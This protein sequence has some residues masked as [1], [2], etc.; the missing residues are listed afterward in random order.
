MAVFG[1]RCEA[2]NMLST[3]PLWLGPLTPDAKAKLPGPPAK[4]LPPA[5][6]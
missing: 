6:P 1:E 4:T 2:I 3:R 5:K